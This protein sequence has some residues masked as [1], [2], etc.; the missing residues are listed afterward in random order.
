MPEN[1]TSQ[2]PPFQ[3]F[4]LPRERNV[5]DFVLRKLGEGA[6]PERY[7]FVESLLS[8][9]RTSAGFDPFALS[10]GRFRRIKASEFKQM[11]AEIDAQIGVILNSEEFKFQLAAEPGL[12]ALFREWSGLSQSV[13]MHPAL[14][15][16]SELDH[17]E[18]SVKESDMPELQLLFYRMHA[19]FLEEV[20]V[21][22]GPDAV[23][24]KF[25]QAVLRQSQLQDQFRIGF[26]LLKQE[27]LS[28]RGL[29]DEEASQLL[30]EETGRLLTLEPQ[31]RN[32]C[33][34]L[35]YIARAAV[36]TA[37]PARNLSVYLDFFGEYLPQILLFRPD[38]GR[39]VQRM[40]AT[41]H[42]RAGREQRLAWLEMAEAEARKLDLHDE[43]PDF[44][45]I[46][47]IIETDEGRV[48]A[49]LTALNDAE[50]LIYKASSRSLASRNNWVLL[51]EYRTL[52]FT[53]KG[54]EGDTAMAG[55][56]TLLQQLAEDMGRH[57]HELSVMMLEWKSLQSLL[58]GDLEDAL[59][60]FDRAKTYR[61]NTP[62]H[63]WMYIDR[64][65]SSLLAPSKKKPSAESIALELQQ[66]GEPFYT[67]VMTEIMKRSPAFVSSKKALQS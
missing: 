41:Y 33:L 64:Y 60:G 65:F 47:C 26:S 53:L 14:S 61:K 5:L 30:L 50:H 10:K 27:Q 28:A 42:L 67:A 1:R 24:E 55:Q 59:D 66:Q 19:A 15:L 12:D 34:L 62:L 38:A 45:F 4:R 57:R 63:P 58:M 8:M 17:F 40:M 25:N 23:L 6:S 31:L 22:D 52:L 3:L 36:L 46:R 56:M 49:A 35:L 54:L 44:R 2:D 51:S 48:D 9:Y 43:R 18:Q 13:A 29:R 21:K 32:R 16:T 20:F 11:L 7:E 39:M 37:T